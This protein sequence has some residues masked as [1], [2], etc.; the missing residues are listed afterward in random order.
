LTRENESN[1]QLEEA[2]V[3]QDKATDEVRNESK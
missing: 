1:A 3:K 2:I